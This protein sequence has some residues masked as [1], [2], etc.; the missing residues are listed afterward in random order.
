MHIVQTLIQQDVLH[1]TWRKAIH[2]P[3]MAEYIIQKGEDYAKNNNVNWYP[4]IQTRWLWW[5]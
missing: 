5:L 1:I 4:L 3:L 2:V